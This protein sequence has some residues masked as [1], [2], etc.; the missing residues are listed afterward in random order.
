[1]SLL[2]NELQK[3]VDAGVLTDDQ[4]QKTQS[5]LSDRLGAVEEFGPR[6]RRSI[7]SEAITYIGGALIVV[8]AILLLSNT[9]DQ[10][11][12]WG[13]PGVI[14]ASATMLFGSS[15]VLGRGHIDDVRR[16]LCSALYAASAAL[17]AFAVSL[18]LNELWLPVQEMNTDYVR[19]AIWVEGTVAGL[20]GLAAAAIAYAGYRKAHSALLV[21]GFGG[22]TGMTVMST[23]IVLSGYVRGRDEYP[24][25]GFA[26]LL[27]AAAVWTFKISPRMVT[28]KVSG[29]VIGLI[30]MLI[31]TEGLRNPLP[32]ST[33]SFLL[34]GL[35]VALMS[36][37]LQNRE[38]PF[39][40][41]GIAGILMGG[42]ELIQ[43]YVTG[44]LGPLVSM[45]LGVAMIVVG[46]RL[47]K[48]HSE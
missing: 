22:A 33:A 48:E 29:R 11:G 10:L 36:V 45:A 5:A 13:R 17:T 35:G 19:P 31:G 9:W 16:R 3:L 30:G 2:I 15:V 24:I 18:V 20:S 4:A 23:G 6:S 28:E 47:F 26:L 40:A 25:Y 41:T 39:L 38:W 42:V 12:T 37:Y 14:G 7:V 21:M 32:E 43:R 1:M 34:V 46:M 44:P 27:L 8:S